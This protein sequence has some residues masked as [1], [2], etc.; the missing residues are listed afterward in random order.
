MP[1]TIQDCAESITTRLFTVNWMRHD[2]KTGDRI[3]IKSQ[4]PSGEMDLGG[5]CYDAAKKA[6][7]DELRA[8]LHGMD[9]PHNE[10]TGDA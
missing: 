8:W 6:V 1:L 3:A 4:E 5:Y 2:E 7:E 9:N 10:Q